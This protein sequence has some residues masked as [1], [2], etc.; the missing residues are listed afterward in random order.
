MQYAN[1]FTVLF[2]P[3]DSETSCT[4]RKA[5]KKLREIDKLKFKMNK[6][7]EEYEKIRQESFWRAIVDPVLT[8][9]SETPEDI[10]QR[11][12]KQREKSQIKE[13]KRKLNAQK[14]KNKQEI[15]LMQRNMRLLEEEHQRLNIENQ[16]LNEEN[17]QLKKRNCSPRSS[18]NY[19]TE[20][21]SLEEKIEEEFHDLYRT[22]GC[23]KQTYKELMLKY[24]P[25][26]N[27]SN[28]GHA[29]SAILNILKERYVD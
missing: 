10:E 20:S 29:I 18:F 1:P 16:R 2:E 23:Y 14:E 7:P 11:K 26:K 5:E 3:G 25:D 21:V 13:L 8:G 6:T 12:T 28:S 24:H 4:K 19:N 9:A 15:L 17:Q 27:K 22:N